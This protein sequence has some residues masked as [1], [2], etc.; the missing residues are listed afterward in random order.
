VF[1][2]ADAARVCPD[3]EVRGLADLSERRAPPLVAGAEGED[4][5]LVLGGARR[6]ARH[7]EGEAAGA[8]S[9]T[10]GG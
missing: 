7:L 6:E 2:R 9:A 5:R 1:G 10:G 4:A 3:A 8:G